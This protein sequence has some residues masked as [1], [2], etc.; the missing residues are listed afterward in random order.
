MNG[1]KEK[2]LAI[3]IGTILVLGVLLFAGW[4]W[5]WSPLQETQRLIASTQATV[6]KKTGELTAIMRE[7]KR[8]TDL[9]DKSL[10]PNLSN[11]TALYAAYLRDVFTSNRM[12]YTNL[13]PTLPNET[14][15]AGGK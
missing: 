7:K 11:A 9:A 3:L 15:A 5:F 1:S 13:S 12:E 4:T 8:L 2:S 6:D 14:K 10:P